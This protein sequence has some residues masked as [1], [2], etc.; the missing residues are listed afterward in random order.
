[1]EIT[2]NYGLTA[3]T[4]EEQA[5]EQGYTFGANAEWVEKIIYGL[6]CAYM[7][8]CITESE[9]QKIIKRFSEKILV[10]NIKSLRGKAE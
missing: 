1:M 5:N 10:K 6:K 3:K 8:E 2:F 9:Y 4:L 7:H